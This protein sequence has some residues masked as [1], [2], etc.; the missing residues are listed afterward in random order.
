[1]TRLN[2]AFAANSLAMH[3]A[4]SAKLKVH[5]LAAHHFMTYLQ[6]NVSLGLQFSVPKDYSGIEAYSDAD[7]A[8]ALN[9]KCVSGNMLMMYGSCVFWRSKSYDIIA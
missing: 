8:N 3:V 5:W 2:I 9:L 7:F 6:K 1:M 4:A